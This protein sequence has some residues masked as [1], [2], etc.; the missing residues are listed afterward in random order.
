MFAQPT[1][2]P[3]HPKDFNQLLNLIEQLQTYFAEIDPNPKHHPFQSTEDA[4]RYLLNAL[5]DCRN[6]QGQCLVAESDNNRLIG[7]ISGIIIDHEA[8]NAYYDYTHEKAKEGANGLLYVHPD[9]RGQSLGKT[10][11]ESITT[12]YTQADCD[13]IQLLVSAYN[14]DAISCYKQLGF[15]IIEHKMRAPIPHQFST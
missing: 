15:E 12:Y 11:I 10:L 1:I 4:A 7:F 2:R 6:Q 3:Y 9:F 8:P 13:S 14:S 5:D